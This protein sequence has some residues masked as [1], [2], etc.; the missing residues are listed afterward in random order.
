MKFTIKKAKEF[1][2]KGLRAWAY[3]SKEDFKNASA[4]YFEV[5]GENGEVKTKL[6]DRIYYVLGGEGEFIL[7]SKK[8]K[9]VKGDVVI[10]PKNTIYNYKVVKGI[11]KMF[12]VHT[13]AYDGDYEIRYKKR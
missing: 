6:S 8:F 3:N 1:G 9:V 12:L 10:V 4:V 7:N 5:K 13:P 11:L 2:W